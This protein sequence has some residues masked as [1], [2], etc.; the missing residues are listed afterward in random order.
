MRAAG[1][2]PI[3]PALARRRLERLGVERIY[4]G[5]E[6]T[7]AAPED[8]FSHRRDGLTGRQASLIWLEKWT[9]PAA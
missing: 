8:Y 7:S 5:D 9:L 1:I 2:W 4:G 3:C 6:C